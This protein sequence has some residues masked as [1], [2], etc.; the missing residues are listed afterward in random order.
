MDSFDRKAAPSA[1]PERVP[2]RKCAGDHAHGS[3]RNNWYPPS[4]SPKTGLLLHSGWDNTARSRPGI[5][6]SF[7]RRYPMAAP[8]SP[9][10]EK[11]ITEGF[12]VVRALRAFDPRTVNK[13]LGIQYE[14]N[15]LGR[16]VEAR[17]RRGVFS[18]GR[19][20]YFFAARLP[21]R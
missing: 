20:G 5:F 16:R 19:E 7:D 21:E 17:R 14:C 8:R 12:G 15:H 11:R 18:G 6:R 4:Y 1:L 9:R 3:L 10:I 13:K 2:G